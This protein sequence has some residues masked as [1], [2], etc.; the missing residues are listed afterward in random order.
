MLKEVKY[1]HKINV[2]K[3]LILE[4][5]HNNNSILHDSV[6]ENIK[7]IYYSTIIAVFVHTSVIL[8]FLFIVPSDTFIQTNWKKGIILTHTCL[9]VLMVVIFLITYNLRNQ[10]YL[11]FFTFILQYLFIVFIILAGVIITTIDQLITTSITPFILATVTTGTIFLIRPL[12]SFFIY[13]G[14]FAFYCKIISVTCT[15][16]DLLLSN[17]VNGLLAVALGFAL[18]LFMWQNFSLKIM[19]QR[20]IE[21]Q[22]NQLKQLAYHDFLTNL[23]N[24]RFF[25]EIIKKEM[26]S[27]KLYGYESYIIVIDIDDFKNINDTYGHTVG[28]KVLKQ[29]ATLLQNNLRA[30]DT[31]A[32]LG[33]EEFII[34][35]SRVS[36]EEAKIVA[37]RFREIIM[38]NEFIV[39]EFTINITASLGLSI[40]P[41]IE[42]IDN[43]Y[44]SAD[45][46][47]YR[48]KNDGKNKVRIN[49]F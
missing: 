5:I 40:L 25:D 49:L 8:Y 13:L 47:L 7:R 39:N 22:Q 35:L 28:D 29:L 32:R 27:I 14:S 23:P 3:D 48:A 36:L 18:S 33:G 16:G 24:R 26:A 17:R 20:K 31:I 15:S 9:L 42:S 4:L 34:L 12:I 2:F 45:K 10:Q 46:A 11:T 6:K 41:G 38:K 1:S 21:N 30:S 43:Y 44:Q 37:D 19:Q